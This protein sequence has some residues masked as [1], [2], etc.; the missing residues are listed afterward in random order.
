M[1]HYNFADV[2]KITLDTYTR[3]YNL[4]VST[5]V[6]LLLYDTR[7]RCIPFAAAVSSLTVRTETEERTSVFECAFHNL[8]QPES[9]EP[10]D[11][12]EEYPLLT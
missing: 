11:D 1:S 9:A 4:F 10:A 6:L 2:V 7:S 12:I 3:K 8:L 5:R